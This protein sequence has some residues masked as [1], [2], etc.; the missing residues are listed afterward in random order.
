MINFI[1]SEEVLPE[2][3]DEEK[4]NMV[5]IAKGHELLD[6]TASYEKI[7]LFSQNKKKN[8]YIFRKI[9]LNFLAICSN[10]SHES[11]IIFRNYFIYSNCIRIAWKKRTVNI[12]LKPHLL[13][14]LK[15]EYFFKQFICILYFDFQKVCLIH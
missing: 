7:S 10:N 1:L 3:S 6:E 4:I 9:I 2:L 11:P 8:H 5:I 15:R 13:L 14:H 12:I